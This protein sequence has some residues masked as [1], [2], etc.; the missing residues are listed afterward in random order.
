MEDFVNI[1]ERTFDTDRPILLDEIRDAFPGMPEA[2]HY[3]RL[4][5]AVTSSR[6]AK[7]C[8]GVYY[9]P[10]ETRFGPSTLNDAR[11]LEKK[12]LT[13]GC[14][15]YGYITGSALENQIGIPNQVPGTLEIV[16]NRSPPDRAGSNHTEATARSP[17]AVLRSP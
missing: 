1:L 5:S 9:A 12:Y 4:R 3:R 7:P 10:T 2:T 11:I 14:K 6:P 15:V 17:C 8:K 13:D 16:T